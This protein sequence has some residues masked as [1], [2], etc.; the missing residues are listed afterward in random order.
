MTWNYAYTPQI[1]PSILMVVLMS[2]L[3]FY[4]GRRRSVPGALQL[5]FACLFAAAW[6]ASLMM[7]YAAVDMATKILWLKVQGIVQLPIVVTIT[8]F[9]LEYAWPGRWLTRRNLAL[10]FLP[11]MLGVILILTSDLHHQ[12]WRSFS[13]ANGALLPQ[14]GL[15]SWILAFYFF[16]VMGALNL[17]VFGW[18]FR[19]SPQH[20]WPVA[21]MLAGQIVGRSLFLLFNSNPSISVLPLN[22]MGMAFEF[23][24]Y[25]IVLFGFR[26]FDPIPLARQTAIQQLHAGM[27]VLDPHGSIVSLNPAA[28]RILGTTASHARG[29]PIRELLPAYPQADFAKAGRAEI[30]LSLPEARRDKAGAGEKLRCY[31]LELSPLKDWRGLEVGRLLLMHDMTATKRAQAQILEQQRALAVLHEREQLARELHDNLGQVLGYVSMQA[32]GIRKRARDGDLSSIDPQLTRLAEV[33]QEA[34]KEIRDSIFGLKS[35]PAEQWSFFAVLQQRLSECQEHFGLHTE[36]KIPKEMRADIFGPEV[37]VQ[38]LRVIQ[39]SLSNARKHGHAGC[40][41]ISFEEKDHLA[42][43]SLADDGCGFDLGGL[44]NQLEGHYGL[45]FM[46]QRMAQVGGRLAIHTKPG[47]G[48]QVILQVPLWEGRRD[49]AVKG[50]SGDER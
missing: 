28:E 7:N 22:L 2:V 19:R 41:K 44:E 37:G 10:L 47:A 3:S 21:L 49:D 12:T 6:S 16:G 30:E 50:R 24:I 43:I 18:L 9:I 20:R 31:T 23:L 27:L 39:E 35:T 14:Y 32:Q 38:V 26:I 4:S 11:V 5:I 42:W 34:H 13:L 36:L 46:R 45:V 29:K 48:T 15:G 40:V 17:I 25:A 33:A 8:C 1:W